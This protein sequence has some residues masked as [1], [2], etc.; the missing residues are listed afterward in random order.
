MIHTAALRP[1]AGG[2]SATLRRAIARTVAYADLFEYP[3]DRS[4]VHRYLIGE[5]ASSEDVDGM[6]EQDG[7]LGAYLERTG[8]KVHL[9]GRASTVETRRMREAASAE[10]WRAARAYGAWVSRLP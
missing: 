4:E 2:P 9:R 8:D 3:L 5:S 6:L 10:M 7:A 1:R